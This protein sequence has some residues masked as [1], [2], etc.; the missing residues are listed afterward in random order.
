MKLIPKERFKLVVAHKEVDRPVIDF[1]A[2]PEIVGGLKNHFGVRDYD[3]LLDC[4]D[5]D[6]RSI[7]PDYIGPPLKTFP[8]G[9]SEDMFGIRRRIIDTPFGKTSVEVYHPLA[10]MNTIDEFRKGYDFPSYE[11]F[12]FGGIKEKARR[13]RKYVLNAGWMSIWY[14]YFFLRGMEQAL[15]DMSLSEEFFRYIMKSC[16]DFW[17]GYMQRTLE[18]ADGAIDYVMAY[19]DFGTTEG[20]LISPEAVREKVLWVYKDFSSF[21]EEYGARFAFHSCGSIH[22]II[23]DLIEKGV[24]ILDPIQTSAKGMD[25]SFLK[26][27]YGDRLTFRGAIDTTELLPRGTAE[28]VIDKVKFTISTLGRSGGYIFCSSNVINADVPLENVLT[29]YRTAAARGN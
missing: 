16:G 2:A 28:E 4:L 9:S 5:V 11:Y 25:I 7:A 23:P 20:L 19:E 13:Y 14:L 6:I 15:I 29:M 24:S 22:Q 3:E 12:D 27:R 10:N 26:N 17:Q 18:A 21:L 8:D 1:E